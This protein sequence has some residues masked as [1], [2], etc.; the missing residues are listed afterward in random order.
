MVESK[1]QEQLKRAPL[2]IVGTKLDL[3]LEGKSRKDIQNNANQWLN[4][5]ETHKHV[6][7]F[8]TSAFK[9]INVSSVFDWTTTKAHLMANELEQ[10]H[11]AEVKTQ[12][13]TPLVTE[14]KVSFLE[15][16]TIF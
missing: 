6:K 7:Y 13:E 15:T 1:F 2:V 9:N 12:E 14:E 5:Q 4:E 16:C 8:E 10:F 11:V 3:N